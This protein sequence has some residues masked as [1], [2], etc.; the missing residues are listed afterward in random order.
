M[1]I[2]KWGLT[3]VLCLAV[4]LPV[5]AQQDRLKQ[6]DSE[7]R[8][9]AQQAA[10]DACGSLARLNT[11]PPGE[12]PFLI[13]QAA[14]VSPQGDLPAYCRVEGWVYPQVGFELRLPMDEAWNGKYLMQGCGGSCGRIKIEA[15]DDALAR[16]YAVTSTDMG[17]KGM[18]YSSIWAYNNRQA[19]IDFGYRGT[20]VATDVTQRITRIF[21]KT[22]PDFRYFRGCSTGGRQ[23]LVAAQRY[24]DYFDG[25]TSGAP[26]ASQTGVSVLHLGWSVRANFDADGEPILDGAKLKY[27]TQKALAA[28]DHLDGAEDGVISNPLTC[29]FTAEQAACG[30]AEDTSKCLVP[31]EVKVLEDLYSGA[32]TSKGKALTV[33]TYPPGVEAELA[34]TIVGMGGNPPFALQQ[35]MLDDNYRYQIFDKDRPQTETLFDFDYDRDPKKL[36]TMER[37]YTWDKPDLTALKKADAKLFMYH[38]W[39]DVEIPAYLSVDY[40]EKAV[41]TLGGMDNAQDTARLF[42]V[43][44]M[45]HCRRGD[46]V[47]SFDTLT[48]M[49]RWVETGVAPDKIIASHLKKPEAYGGLPVPRHPLPAE[50]VSFTRPLYPHPSSA[51]YSGEGDVNEAANWHRIMP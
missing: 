28:C 33:R 17:H 40:Y 7:A 20:Q 19:E 43:P 35:P 12:Y 21:Y 37:I 48:V 26:V 10:K 14:V 6:F 9:K 31:A 42:L 1:P 27:V 30:P 15:A 38:G 44:G 51:Q 46:G 18:P 5:S 22:D 3:A 8:V 25:I 16:G 2:S 24:P 11:Q 13:S 49:E 39:N 23:A 50:D 45:A 32:R 47:N 36:K 29:P 41:K 4:T 34:G